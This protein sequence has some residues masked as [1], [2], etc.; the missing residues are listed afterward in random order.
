MPSAPSLRQ[1]KAILDRQQQDL[2]VTL[3]QQLDTIAERDLRIE[4]LEQ[5][6][7]ELEDLL[8]SIRRMQ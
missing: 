3:A 7:L 2:T 5:R 1:A 4:E 8:Q 6:I